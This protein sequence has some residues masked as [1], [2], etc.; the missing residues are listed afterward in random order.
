MG[1]TRRYGVN[2]KEEMAG[3]LS[4]SCNILDHVETRVFPA[5]SITLIITIRKS[6]LLPLPV[7]LTARNT[8]Y[9]K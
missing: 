7:E 3:L 1:T 6:I 9:T 5:I 4:R 2:N 8:R